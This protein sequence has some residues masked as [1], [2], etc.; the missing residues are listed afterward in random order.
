METSS[1]RFALILT[2]YDKESE[3]VIEAVKECVG[4]EDFVA[5]TSAERTSGGNLV[6]AI[7]TNIFHA[8]LIICDL[9]NTKADRKS[10]RLNSSHRL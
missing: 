10:T 5:Y 4:Q 2:P 6:E 9:T 1:E 7:V 3:P 8:E